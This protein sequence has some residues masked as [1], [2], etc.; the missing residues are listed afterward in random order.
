MSRCDL[1]VW[2][3]VRYGYIRVGQGLGG[4]CRPMG[5]GYGG[6]GAQRESRRISV[7]GP[8]NAVRS[9]TWISNHVGHRTDTQSGRARARPQSE[10]DPARALHA[11]Y[12]PP[13]GAVLIWRYASPPPSRPALHFPPPCQNGRAAPFI[14]LL[15]QIAPD[16]CHMRSDKLQD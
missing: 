3:T 15:F 13:T 12:T 4:Q 9:S 6:H 8:F 16:I 11:P 7:T 1:R 14:V 5:V 2:G 10:H